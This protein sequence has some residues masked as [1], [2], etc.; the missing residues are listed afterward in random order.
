MGQILQATDL[1]LVTSILLAIPYELAT[2][3]VV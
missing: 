1:R 2:I 3:I